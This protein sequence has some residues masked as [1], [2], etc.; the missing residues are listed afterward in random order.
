MENQKC[1]RCHGPLLSK[2]VEHPYWNGPTL[3]ALIHDVPSWVCQMCGYHYFDPAVETTLR[4]IVQDY[5]KM[6][7]LFP[8]PTTPYRAIDSK[9][10]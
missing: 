8:V 4:F 2:N 5:V 7:S 6:G 1:R 10:S 3:V 9:H